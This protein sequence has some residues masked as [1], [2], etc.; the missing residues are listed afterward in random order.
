MQ[1]LLFCALSFKSFVSDAKQKLYKPDLIFASCSW[2]AMFSNQA[3]LILWR[4]H[5]PPRQ[6]VLIWATTTFILE[7]LHNSLKLTEMLSLV[8]EIVEVS[9]HVRSIFKGFHLL[10]LVFP[11]IFLNDKGYRHFMATDN[12]KSTKQ[13]KSETKVAF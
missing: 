3:R 8:G 9:E 13:K 5:N 2:L 12:L 10:S 4:V 11:W 6:Q 7:F 1:T